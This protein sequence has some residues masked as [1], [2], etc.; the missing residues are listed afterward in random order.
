MAEANQKTEKT[1]TSKVSKA[2]G[3]KRPVYIGLVIK[4]DAG[5]V[6]SIKKENVSVKFTTR[7]TRKV[8]EELEAN[9]GMLNIKTDI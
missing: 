1:G 8:V 5:N 4:D 9:P 3:M 6:L 7:D 2:K